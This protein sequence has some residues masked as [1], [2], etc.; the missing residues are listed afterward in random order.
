M[1]NILIFSLIV[2]VILSIYTNQN[3][4]KFCSY[5]PIYKCVLNKHLQRKCTWISSCYD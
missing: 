5:K 3:N 4:E 2:I 1:N